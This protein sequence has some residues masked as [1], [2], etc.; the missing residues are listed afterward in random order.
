MPE[1]LMKEE[2]PC[3]RPLQA[4]L[5]MKNEIAKIIRPVEK[6]IVQANVDYLKQIFNCKK[7]ILFNYISISW[8]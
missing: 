7:N 5:N 2:Q 6:Q 3:E 1:V 4:L 8:R